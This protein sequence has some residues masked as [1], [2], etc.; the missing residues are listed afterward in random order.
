M[1][2]IHS[3][4]DNDWAIAYLCARDLYSSTLHSLASPLFS[5]YRI[6][7]LSRSYLS[8]NSLPIMPSWLILPLM[9]FIWISLPFR[10]WFYVPFY[11]CDQASMCAALCCV[12]HKTACVSGLE[13]RTHSYWVIY[14]PCRTGNPP[15]QYARSAVGSFIFCVVISGRLRVCTNTTSPSMWYV[16][17]W[18]AFLNFSRLARFP[19]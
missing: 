15:L 18:F 3:L 10:P 16:R 9:S 2:S 13:L 14:F 7:L 17:Q 12:S 19:M 5:T 6:H 1:K 8:I 11:V 4:H